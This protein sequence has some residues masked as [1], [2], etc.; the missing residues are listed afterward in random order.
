[1]LKSRYSRDFCCPDPK[2]DGKAA[3]IFRG[4]PS[5]REDGAG[6]ET[7]THPHAAAAESRRC[8]GEIFLPIQ[9]Y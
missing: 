8:F 6:A 1:M 9:L 2:A 3:E 4:L 7:K 5:R